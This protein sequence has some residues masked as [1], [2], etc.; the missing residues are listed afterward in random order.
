[1]EGMK[2]YYATQARIRYYGRLPNDI[3]K[4][5]DEVSGTGKYSVWG[6]GA[7]QAD[8]EA[9][10]ESASDQPFNL[11]GRNEPAH[12]A[13]A[14]MNLDLD[15]LHA[16]GR[17]WGFVAGDVDPETGRWITR[18]RDVG[19]FHRLLQRAWRGEPG[20]LKAIAKNL[21]SR[22]DVST[23]GIDIAIVDLMS[24]IRLMFLR[25]YAAGRAKVCENPAC[26]SPYFLQQRKGQQYCTHQCAVLINVRRFRQR[27]TKGRAETEQQS[28]RSPESLERRK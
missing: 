7:L 13:F 25:D 22:V 4:G 17:K 28:K 15:S 6:E 21:K 8:W 24:L 12:V 5:S 14:N 1:M 10:L 20:A 26:L 23:S 16:F 11:A 19:P 3:R 18:P 2:S 27:Q 9:Y